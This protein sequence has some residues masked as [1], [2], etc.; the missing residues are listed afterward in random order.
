MNKYEQCFL[1]FQG[2]HGKRKQP[3]YCMEGYRLDSKT[4]ERLKDVPRCQDWFTWNGGQN[5]AV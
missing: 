1:T 5:Q 4:D 2:D 3:N